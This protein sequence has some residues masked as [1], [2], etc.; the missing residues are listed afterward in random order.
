MATEPAMGI[1][2]RA[3]SAP[4]EGLLEEIKAKKMAPYY[5]YIAPKV[6]W[7]IDGSLLAAMKDANG[8]ELA[9]LQAAKEE[10][11]KNLGDME[12]LDALFAIAAFHA[13]IGDKAGTFEACDAIALKPKVSTG[14]K[15]DALMGKLRI[16]LFYL[17]V[18]KDVLAETKKLA[19]SGGD[20]D[21]NNRLGVYEAIVAI[22]NRDFKAAAKLLL[23]GVATFTC[24]ELCDYSDFVFYAVLT[25]LLSLSRPELKKKVVEGPEILQI[26]KQIPHLRE[27]VVSLYDCEYARFF[28]NLLALEDRIKQDRYLAPHFRYL[29]REMRVLAYTQFLDA[30][31][32][33]T[34]KAMAAVFGVSIPF[35]DQELAH[36]ISCGRLN[37]KIDKVDLVVETNR[38]DSKSAHYQTIIKQGDLL[39]NQI[40]KLARKVS[41]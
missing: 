6:G 31:K 2:Q 29:I 20:W 10:A 19:D 28:S 17:E 9:F 30:Y 33:V 39:L 23:S 36:F 25:N 5:E 41:I 34:L 37:A 18:D 22:V 3:F 11:E 7:T 21:R 16:A 26:I 8:A 24:T 40:Q 38:P 32:T 14:K 12:V 1:A 27:L 13:R 15:I 4:D 35:L